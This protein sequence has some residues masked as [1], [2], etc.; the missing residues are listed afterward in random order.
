MAIPFFDPSRE[1]TALE[2]ELTASFASIVRSSQIVLGR[3]VLA[4]EEEFAD[5]LGQGVC[6]GVGN[7]TDAISIALAALGAKRGDKVI[8]VSLTALAT[9]AGILRAGACPVLIDV[10]PSTGLMDI[11]QLE[12]ELSSDIFAVV[13]VNLYGN[14]DNLDCIRRLCDQHGVYMLEDCAQSLGAVSGQK[15]VGTF[16]HASTFSFY[17]SKTLGAIGDGGC[18]LFRDFGLAERA[19][20]LRQYG[21]D[22]DRNGRSVGINSRLDEL[23]ASI[24]RTKLK[25]LD[26]W[27][28]S[29]RQIA[30]IYKEAVDQSRFMQVVCPSDALKQGAWHLFVVK[31]EDQ[32]NANIFF[33]ETRNVQTGIHYRIPA[34]KHVGYADH[35][36]I[37]NVTNSEYLSGHILSLP[38]YPF[39]SSDEI[40]SVK[41]S[42]LAYHGA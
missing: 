2:M 28:E 10:D 8:T 14:S 22:G 25:F 42:I 41:E 38:L 12:N 31:L 15:S 16:G 17:P 26:R 23:Q 18:I 13:V 34:H 5:Y 27:I 9:V 32:D 39:M 6:V 40:H 35:C 36:C 4:F 20:E 33:N 29:R 3:N 24:L 21:W 30:A 7:G 11:E 37:R 1:N 19:R